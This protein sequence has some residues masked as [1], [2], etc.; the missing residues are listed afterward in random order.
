MSRTSGLEAAAAMLLVA[1][2]LGTIVARALPVGGM[3]RT[4]E[5]AALILVCATPAIALLTPYLRRH[6]WAPAAVIACGYGSFYLIRSFQLRR[7]NRDTV[8]LLLGLHRDATFGEV[9]N[10]AERINPRPLTNRGRLVIAAVAAAI[11][12]IGQMTGR[13]D[14]ALIG[15]GLGA[16]E[17]TLRPAYHRRLVDRIRDIGH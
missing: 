8:R 10:E 11:L 4:A 6:L 9:W 5:E 15:L 2:F 16:A 14:T 3:R 1:A 7:A 13:Y 17:S 12:V